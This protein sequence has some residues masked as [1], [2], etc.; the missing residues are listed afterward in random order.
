MRRRVALP[1]RTEPGA[2][3]LHLGQIDARAGWMPGAKCRRSVRTP[4]RLTSFSR[5]PHR[6]LSGHAGGGLSQSAIRS[7]CRPPPRRDAPAKKITGTAMRRYTLEM[8]VVGALHHD[9]S[10]F[11]SPAAR[12]ELHG[13]CRR[14]PEPHNGAGLPAAS[15]PRRRLACRQATALI[16]DQLPATPLVLGETGRRSA[17]GRTQPP[18]REA[19]IRQRLRLAHR[20]A[21]GP[22]WFAAACALSV[23][24]RLREA[25]NAQIATPAVGPPAIEHGATRSGPGDEVDHLERPLRPVRTTLR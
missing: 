4:R 24:A 1:T 21:T 20:L 9:W 17:P 12:A 23:R 22:S 7:L 8:G 2:R 6:N 5:K 10:R 19:G 16:P 25:A 18:T 11:G 13:V 3:L 14:G 15:R